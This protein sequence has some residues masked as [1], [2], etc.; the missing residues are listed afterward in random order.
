MGEAPAEPTFNC[1]N[2]TAR[3][4]P[5]PPSGTRIY[6]R[7][8]SGGVILSHVDEAGRK[9]PS[10][11][12]FW[13]LHQPTI[14][15]VTVCTKERK[16][17]LAC[18]EAHAALLGAW[19][20]ADAWGVGCYVV[21]PDHVHFFCAP[22]NLDLP[23]ERWMHFWKGRFRKLCGRKE[24]RWQSNHWDT[25]LRRSERYSESG[26]TYVEIQCVPA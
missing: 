3:Q 19:A 5:R 10:H 11:G 6:S 17:W 23:L 22:R 20:A 25:R 21:M 16:P 15:F 4:E 9:H 24:W 7:P 14:V 2:S 18:P 13:S 8:T 26:I 1:W 12:V